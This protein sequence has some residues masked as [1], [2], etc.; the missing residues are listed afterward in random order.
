MRNKNRY[1]CYYYYHILLLLLLPSLTYVRSFCEEFG[2]LKPD[3]LC[4]FFAL[5][6]DLS[7]VIT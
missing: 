6:Y 5:S 1:Y 3:F 4:H 2:G 7:H